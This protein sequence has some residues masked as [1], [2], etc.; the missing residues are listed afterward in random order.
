MIEKWSMILNPS[1]PPPSPKKGSIQKKRYLL[2]LIVMKTQKCNRCRLE[3]S[4]SDGFYL[5][6]GKPEKICKECRLLS[7][8][9]HRRENYDPVK[10]RKRHLKRSKNGYFRK[11]FH[12]WVEKYPEKYKARYALR[13]A[14][15]YGK[16]KKLSCQKCGQEK[17]QA[18][19]YDYS[20]PL[21]VIWLC[22][23]H[24]QELHFQSLEQMKIEF[25][26]RKSLISLSTK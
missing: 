22:Q 15:K 24:H 5:N 11:A 4:L 12:K 25:E 6:T 21:D 18:H 20:K 13:N 9:I 17:V 26:N 3:K 8:K 1:S 14:V 2:Y 16:V 19:H 10:E 7:I 23:K